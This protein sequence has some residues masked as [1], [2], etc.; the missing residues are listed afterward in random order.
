MISDTD[1]PTRIVNAQA[2]RFDLPSSLSIKNIAVNS[3]MMMAKSKM[4][5]IVF[6]GQA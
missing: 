5:T 6:I 4:T 3:A 2:V 1:N